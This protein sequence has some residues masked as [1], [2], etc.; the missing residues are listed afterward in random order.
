MGVSSP[1]KSN[2]QQCS[3]AFS[4]EA[5]RK[6]PGH[7]STLDLANAEQP[8]VPEKYGD[9][10]M[11]RIISELPSWQDQLSTRGYIVG[12]SR[13][14]CDFQGAAQHLIVYKIRWLDIYNHLNS[15]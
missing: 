13:V 15:H 9:D 14:M 3:H 7:G 1:N 10:D 12:E 6:R 8:A 11:E 2:A 5:V 4:A